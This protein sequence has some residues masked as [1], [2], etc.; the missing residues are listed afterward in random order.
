MGI[1]TPLNILAACTSFAFIA[2]ICLGYV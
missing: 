1:A 2:A